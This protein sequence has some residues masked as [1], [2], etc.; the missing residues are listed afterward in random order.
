MSASLI[1]RLDVRGDGRARGRAHGEE[2][3]ELIHDH[4]E[5]W[6]IALAAEL[7]EHPD[8]YVDRFLSETNFMP[9][10]R[11]WTPDLLAEVEG[12]SE[13]ARADFRY[14]LV[15]QLSDEEPWYRRE[16][17]LAQG[18]GRGCS[19]VGADATTGRPA[20]IA[21]NMDT[22]AWWNG[23][24]ML[25]KVADENGLEAFVFTVVGKISL[26]GLNNFG[27]GICC[28]TLSQ[29]NYARDGLPEDFVV[30]GFLARRS[31]EEGIAFLHE[32]K[33]AS[34]QNYTLGGPNQQVVNLECSA[35]RVVAYRPF[36]F[37]D[38][39][40]HTNH[41]IVN[42]DVDS[43]RKVT[44][45]MDTMALRALYHG[46]SFA[47]LAELQFAFGDPAN[48]IGKDDIVRALSSHT[49]PVCRHADGGAGNYTLGTLV[50]E[51]TAQP[52][53]SIAAGPPCRT[54]FETFAFN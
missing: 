17:K 34:G 7:D 11:R 14:T 23:H 45:K 36:P 1:R 41:P 5:R 38:R 6:K 28:N 43:F 47:R 26:C 54:P 16:R 51:L 13:G 39:V 35:E 33:H 9:A 31:L 46:S 2:L 3:R 19:S 8:I 15:R 30:R 10:I 32:I 20:L 24:Q 4:L 42:D 25:M 52:R 48:P 44:A 29:L 27:V 21:Q 50:M 18:L 53:L 37:A 40:F 49:G 22:P 12:I